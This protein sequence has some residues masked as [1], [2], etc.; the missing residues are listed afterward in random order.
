MVSGYIGIHMCWFSCFSLWLEMLVP[1]VFF[2]GTAAGLKP[3]T[4]RWPLTVALQERSFFLSWLWQV[5][6]QNCQAAYPALLAKELKAAYQLEA[7]ALLSL[8]MISSFGAK[9]V[10]GGWPP[11]FWWLELHPAFLSLFGSL[12]CE[13]LD[14]SHWPDL[15][16]G[17]GRG[18]IP[19]SGTGWSWRGAKRLSPRPLDQLVASHYDPTRATE[20]L[21]N[22]FCSWK[23]Q[24]GHW[25][26]NPNESQRVLLPRWNEFRS[27]CRGAKPQQIYTTYTNI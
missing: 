25:K 12:S 26:K 16:F 8:C 6:E 17:C 4:R 3:A 2:L 20:P 14:F 21:R 9:N 7:S 27:P 18:I 1:N 11:W 24:Q 19:A 5:T 15:S 22:G 13:M 23:D 10:V